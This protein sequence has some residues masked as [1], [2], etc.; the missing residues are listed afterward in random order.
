MDEDTFFRGFIAALRLTGHEFVETRGDDQHRRFSAVVKRIDEL[1]AKGAP[2][3]ENLPQL[4]V[5]SPLTNR[6]PE[7]DDALLEA[8]RGRTGSKNPY[9]PGADL[10]LT[11]E[12][13]KQELDELSKPERD[14][15]EDLVA[16]F[17]AAVPRSHVTV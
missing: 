7:L 6:F 14:L 11:E 1:V 5:A 16:T 17:L 13:A 15:I 2:S 12:Y 8:Q 10:V 3:A 9:Y 4:F